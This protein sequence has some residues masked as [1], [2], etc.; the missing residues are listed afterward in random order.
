LLSLKNRIN[1]STSL[2]RINSTYTRRFSM[3]PL[4]EIHRKIKSSSLSSIINT[5]KMLNSTCYPWKI[6]I[7]K[8]TSLNRINSTNKKVLLC[9]PFPKFTGKLNQRA[10]VPSIQPAKCWILLVLLEN[11]WKKNQRAS[12]A[13][14]QTIKCWILLVILEK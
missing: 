11:D 8:S 1:K 7:N 4:F 10:S 9:Y 3:L 12:K 5:S 13:S 2:N 6:R 14:I